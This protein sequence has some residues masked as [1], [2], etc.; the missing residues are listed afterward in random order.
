MAFKNEPLGNNNNYQPQ[1]FL[2][3]NSDLMEK[4]LEQKKHYEAEKKKCEEWLV[5]I[6][7]QF[8]EMRE[9]QK[10]IHEKHLVNVEEYCNL[11]SEGELIPKHVANNLKSSRERLQRTTND[12]AEA[13]EEITK[14]ED[15]LK[16]IEAQLVAINKDIMTLQRSLAVIPIEEKVESLLEDILL[17]E[18]ARCQLF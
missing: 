11:E 12:L 3:L 1:F 13:K 9:I 6:I 15:V 8:D 4:F 10:L 17:T 7:T 18:R 2:S 14:N 16:K 5:D